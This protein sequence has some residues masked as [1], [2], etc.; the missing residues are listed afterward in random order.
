MMWQVASPN[1]KFDDA[2]YGRTATS[3]ENPDFVDIVIHSYRHRLGY[4]PGDPDLEAVEQRLA[5]LPAI[6]VQTIALSGGGD[7][8]SVP[9]APAAQAR[10]FTGSIQHQVI[11][12][13]GHNIPQ[14][15]PA[16][17]VAAVLELISPQRT[18][19][20]RPG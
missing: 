11:P 9:A 6:S 13:I 12:V 8:V 4:A 18:G 14:E 16:A 20:R 10:F 1:W 5:T 19:D 17:V 15:A 3:F 2:T 7:G